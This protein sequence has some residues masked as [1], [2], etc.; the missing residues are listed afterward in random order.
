MRKYLIL[1][2]LLLLCLSN[3]GCL[4]AEENTVKE[5]E[6]A[7]TDSVQEQTEQV[8]LKL[9]VVNRPIKW[10]D[11]R[12]A[13]IRAY[14]NLHYGKDIIEIVPQVI[15][16]HWTVSNDAES[17]Y[18]YFYSETM[19]DDGGG[20]LNVASHY[21]VDRDGTIYQLTPE[22]ALNRHA[23]GYNWC[24]IGIENVGGVNGREDLTEEQ[25]K[26]NVDIIRYLQAKYPTIKYV[27][28]HYQQ[29][30]AESSGLFIEK[31]PD[32]YAEKIDPGSIF[33]GELKKNLRDLD[34][35]FY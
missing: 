16:V 12:E 20:R 14:A 33:M 3:L 15:I 26:A 1:T 28:G 5:Q 7:K 10:T 2:L 31:V 27:W 30:E 9:D 13:L 24:A 18:Q 35:K 19:P 11:N 34:L 4:G 32:Y 17:V 29:H 25:V 8:L 23:I 21:L 6:T 22:T